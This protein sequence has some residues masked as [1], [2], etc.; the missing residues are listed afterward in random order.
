MM[1]KFSKLILATL[2]NLIIN[3]SHLHINNT[4]NKNGIVYVVPIL[5]NYFDL[6][7]N[8]HWGLVIWLP[9]CEYCN[10]VTAIA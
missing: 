7:T 9:D 6:V 10:A 5:C 4:T 8:I 3:P 2:P 1:L